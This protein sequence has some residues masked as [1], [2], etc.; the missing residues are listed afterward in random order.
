M[1]A[2]HELMAAAFIRNSIV[3]NDT[4]VCSFIINA[5]LE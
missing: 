1:I 4:T 5:P 2:L 3:H